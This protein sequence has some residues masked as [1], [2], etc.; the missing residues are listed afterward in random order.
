[1][2]KFKSLLLLTAGKDEMVLRM[3]ENLPKIKV[4]RAEDVNVMELLSKETVFATKDAIAKM[5]TIFAK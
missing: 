1:L 3:A 4:W 2:P 5:E